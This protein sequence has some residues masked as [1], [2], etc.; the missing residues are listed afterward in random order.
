M[1][2]GSEISA[3]D[4]VAIQDKAQSVLGPGIGSRGYGQ[5]LSS[6]DVFTGNQITKEQ[7]DL[8]R[9]DIVNI[10]VHQDGVL[11]TIVT[12]NVGDPIGYSAGSPNTNYNTLMDTAIANRFNIASN[13]SIIS[14]AASQTYSSAWGSSAQATL[15]A[16][17]STADQA[18]YFFNSGGKIR[19]TT[20]LTGSSVTSQNN[21]WVNFLNSAATQ[22]FGAATNEFV[23]FYTLTNAYQTYY[24]GSLTTP[25]S[26][27]NYRLEAKSNVADNSSGTATVVELRITLTDSY[28]DSGPPAPGDSVDGTLTIAVDEL[29]ASGSLIPTGS[30]TITSPTYS[31][32]TITAS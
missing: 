12:V 18:R 1:A 25:Y 20:T 5:A 17:F 21:A 7:W 29:K 31:I 24:Q 16:T 13:Q 32:S 27:N 30:F 8:L 6:T 14:A 11:P 3:A 26:A 28:V 9:Y 2:I 10:R 15:T 19:I 4:Y 23:N 22:S